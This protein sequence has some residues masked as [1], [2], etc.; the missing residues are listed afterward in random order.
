MRFLRQHKKPRSQHFGAYQSSALRNTIK[1]TSQTERLRR[2]ANTKQSMLKQHTRADGGS[3][4]IRTVP[5]ALE[6][7]QSPALRLAGSLLSAGGQR[8]KTSRLCSLFASKPRPSQHITAGR[9]LH[10]A[11]KILTFVSA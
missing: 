10:P 11:P 1:Q 5:S 8:F 9:D 7:H 6:S 3:S 4:P 2:R